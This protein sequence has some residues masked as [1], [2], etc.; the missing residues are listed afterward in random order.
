MLAIRVPLIVAGMLLGGLKGVVVARVISGLVSI[1]FA[2]R[3]VRRVTD[4]DLYTQLAAN[5]RAF[6]STAAMAAAVVL[7]S[8][9]LTH[10]SDPT[11]LF[12][13]IA[14]TATL[15]AVVY[16]GTSMLLWVS[17]RRPAGPE[18][19]V[20]LLFSKLFGRLRTA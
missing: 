3:L 15:A 16:C 13:K 17:M 7:I 4:L 6:A 1:Y 12:V 14:V 18:R 9:F 2:M 19:E 11:S 5:A 8:P 20:Q 10:K